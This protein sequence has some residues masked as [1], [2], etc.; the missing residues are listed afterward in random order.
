M[1]SCDESVEKL[2][3]GTP[4]TVDMQWTVSQVE[5]S[6]ERHGVASVP[7]VDSNRKD[8]FGI[9]SLKDIHHFHA[10]KKNAHAVRAWEMCTY[11]PIVIVP[12]TH[13]ADAARLMIE[14]GIHHL[15]VENENH[16]VSGFVSSLDLLKAFV[17]VD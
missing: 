10:A 1:D 14:H 3:H 11:K 12:G 13:V 8:C 4:V 9:I 6:M 16:E 7:V 5:E 2:L 17:S 15:I